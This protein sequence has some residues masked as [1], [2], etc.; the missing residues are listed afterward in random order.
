MQALDEALMNENAKKSKTK[1]PRETK[2]L[3]VGNLLVS[4]GYLT[5]TQLKEALAH[6]KK[7]RNYLPL[8][9]ICIEP[10]SISANYS[11]IWH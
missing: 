4:E 11:L 2:K 1:Q 9:Q 8:G 6:Q 5:R 3:K 10:S 7:A